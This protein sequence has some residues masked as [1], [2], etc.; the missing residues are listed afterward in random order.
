MVSLSL[1]VPVLNE[2]ILLWAFMEKTERDLNESGIDWELFMV[3]DGSSDT[4]L[5]LMRQFAESRP[6]VKV[7]DL[8][9]NHGPGANLYQAYA[10]S[11]KDVVAYAT[12]DGFYDTALLGSLLT[13]FEEHDVVSAY[14][15]DLTSHPGF[16]K[17]QTMINV[18][19]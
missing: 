2:E 8:G 9:S 18:Y 3:D 16:R 14:R 12:V 6:R 1:V 13:H 17:V 19:L 7:I 11:S 4:S 10:M 15:T 5:Q